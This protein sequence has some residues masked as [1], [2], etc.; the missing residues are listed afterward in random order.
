MEED[1]KHKKQCLGS[2]AVAQEE[3]R[4]KIKTLKRIHTKAGVN[5]ENCREYVC[6]VDTKTML[7]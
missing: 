5:M 7:D 1:Q 6:R 3:W 2:E 4:Q